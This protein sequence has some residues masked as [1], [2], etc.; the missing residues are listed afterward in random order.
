[1]TWLMI[2][3]FAFY[4][5]LFIIYFFYNAQ[6]NL[7]QTELIISIII[8]FCF[9]FAIKIFENIEILV[10]TDM[11]MS[12]FILKVISIVHINLL[13]ENSFVNYPLMHIGFHIDIA[14]LL[15]LDV[16]CHLTEKKQKSGTKN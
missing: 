4:L 9:G 12:V 6:N 7:E 5:N 13:P 15:L 16:F 14:L 10:I 11:L 3:C 1:M 2:T 8:I